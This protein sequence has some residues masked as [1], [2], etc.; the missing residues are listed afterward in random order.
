MSGLGFSQSV[1]K[2]PGDFNSIEVFDKISVT[3]IPSDVSKVE[4]T[5]T[6]ANEV[7][8]INKNGALKIKMNLS[9]LL[10]GEDIQAKVYYQAIESVLASEGALIE[11]T[12]VIKS[13]N[14]N[15]TS[16]SG[17]QIILYI[18]NLRTSIKASTGGIV[19]LTGN[20]ENAQINM[21][22]G[23]EL[24]AHQLD[25]KQVTISINAGGNAR[26]KA[27]DYVDAKVRAGGNIKIYGKPAQ[28][29]QKTVL[30][31]SIEQVD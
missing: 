29:D 26:I 27:S 9:K 22:A 5:G 30:G 31:G 12:G 11:A 1:E 20:T 19:T 16:N 6:R 15:V 4:I 7:Q 3:L 24:E 25:A 18:E 10:Q 23:A 14:L 2:N 8:V 13:R 28:I 21:N 17:G